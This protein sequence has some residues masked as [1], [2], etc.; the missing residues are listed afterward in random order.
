M[1][2]SRLYTDPSLITPD[3]LQ[4]AYTAIKPYIQETPLL[5]SPTLSQLTGGKVWV[6]AESLQVTGAFKFRGAL[7]RLMQL[8]PIEKKKGVAA[9]SSGNFARGLAQAGKLLNI[10]VYLVMPHDAPANK[11]HNARKLGAVVMLCRQSIPSR[12]EAASIMAT[13]FAKQEGYT[14]LHP[15]DDLILVKGQATVGIELQKQLAALGQS[16][17]HLLCPAGGGSLVAGCSLTFPRFLTNTQVYSVEVEGF[18]GMRQSLAQGSLTRAAGQNKSCCD[19]LLAVSPGQSTFQIAKETHVK[20]VAVQELSVKKALQL[21]FEELHLVLEPSGAVA[22]GAIIEHPERFS[23]QNT[24]VVAS[25][26]NVD[27]DTYH[28]LLREQAL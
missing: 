23:Q 22:M 8:S 26:G 10:P 14:L 3:M 13:T 5:E 15:F 11:I 1:P 18:D 19:A 9:Y 7:Y 25:G 4:G 24:I 2:D 20:G 21:A 27:F 17:H 28:I 12:E 16:C 6:K